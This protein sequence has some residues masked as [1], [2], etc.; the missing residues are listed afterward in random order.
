HNLRKLL[1]SLIGAVHAGTV[2]RLTSFWLLTLSGCLVAPCHPYRGEA[3][4][5]GPA[6]RPPDGAASVPSF[7]DA[8][9]LRI[10]PQPV[11][12]PRL[13]RPPD[14][15]LPHRNRSPASTPGP[16]SGPHKS[17]LL[18][19]RWRCEPLRRAG[20]AGTPYTDCAR[21]FP[22]QAPSLPA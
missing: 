3:A 12:R 2:P 15:L 16:A 4:I 18:R 11:L 22:I 17:S 5:R 8:R 1:I 7:P 21:G 9:P 19:R 20:A 6:L 10:P 14:A 13:V